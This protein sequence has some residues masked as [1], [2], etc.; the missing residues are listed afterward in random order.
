MISFLR[1][2]Y[3]PWGFLLEKINKNR[4][5]ESISI[6]HAIKE[7]MKWKSGDMQ[8]NANLN[9]KTNG[10]HPSKLFALTQRQ[11]TQQDL[12]PV[13]GYLKDATQKKETCWLIAVHFFHRSNK[14]GT[15]LCVSLM[16]HSYDTEKMIT[17]EKKLQRTIWMIEW[18]NWKRFDSLKNLMKLKRLMCNE[19]KSFKRFSLNI[20]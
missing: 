8:W 17:K 4:E 9:K 7:C 3:A 12:S 13:R 18:Q 11:L 16:G 2:L 10:V 15:R 1:M 19:E 14:N 6:D 5:W 20:N